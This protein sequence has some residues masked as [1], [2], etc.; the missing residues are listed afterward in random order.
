[1]IVKQAF[2]GLW[3]SAL[4]WMINGIS[5]KVFEFKK[6][7]AI[8]LSQ[9]YRAK[10]YV[11]QS[12]YFNWVVFRAKDIELYKRIGAIKKSVTAMELEGLAAYVADPM[13]IQRETTTVKSEK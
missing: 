3:T 12:G 13:R 1:M 11:I 2:R 8:K 5:S 4:Q 9:T 7:E 10:Y 6:K